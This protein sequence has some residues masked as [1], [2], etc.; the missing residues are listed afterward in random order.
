MT[1][2]A[3]PSFL[4]HAATTAAVIDGSFSAGIARARSRERLRVPDEPGVRMRL[5]I[6]GRAD[7]QPVEVVRIALRLDETLAPAVRAGTEIRMRRRLAVVRRDDC[8]G[9]NRRHMLRPVKIV[10][11]LLRMADGPPLV[12]GPMTGVGGC[13]RVTAPQ[14]LI[15]RAVKAVSLVVQL[16][17]EAAF[18]GREELAVPHGGLRQPHLEPDVR[19]GGRLADNLRAAERR[20]VVDRDGIR[21]A[22]CVGRDEGGLD[23]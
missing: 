7:D 6:P 15:H 21:D 13:G 22:E 9:S 19:I 10:G 14:D 12:G 5:K 17:G 1:P 3:R 23:D 20:K 4:S 2:S 18:P 8:L 16:S 11:R